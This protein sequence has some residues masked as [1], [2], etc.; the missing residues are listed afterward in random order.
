MSGNNYPG[1]SNSGIPGIS[2]SKLLSMAVAAPLFIRGTAAAFAGQTTADQQIAEPAALSSNACAPAYKAFRPASQPYVPVRTTQKPAGDI[3][4]PHDF[5]EFSVDLGEI[6]MNFAIAGSS[7]RPALLLLPSQ[8]EQW[9]GYEGAMKILSKDYHVFAV[10]LRGTGRTTITPGR[11]TIPNMGHDLIRFVEKVVRR[12]VITAGNSSGGVLSCWLSAYAPDGMVHAA[13]YEDPPLFASELNPVYGPGVRDT[14]VGP[15]F[16]YRAKY[17]GDQWKIGDWEG[18][19][20]AVSDDIRLIPF[21]VPEKPGQQEKE[22]DPEWARAFYEGTVSQFCNHKT[23][24][25]NVKVPV[26]LT[27]HFNLV[28]PFINFLVGALSDNQAE[29]VRELIEG[30][31]QRFTYVSL[32]FAQHRLHYADPQRYCEILTKWVR[33]LQL[34]V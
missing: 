16:R 10:D 28:V 1:E 23:M 26:V 7:N 29:K 34:P 6:I 11:Y 19:R 25:E 18:Y 5:D 12:P 17:L 21:K 4:I 3:Y 14:I 27:H 30:A 32:P 24:L 33:E 13:C 8:G 22:Y 9:W 20:K 31:G 2:R 15:K